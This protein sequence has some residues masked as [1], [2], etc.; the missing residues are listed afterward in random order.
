MN[1]RHLTLAQ[2]YQIQGLLRAGF[3]NRSIA[4]QVGWHPS[5]ISRE[6]RRNGAQGGYQA[7]TAQWQARDRRHAASSVPRIAPTT[8]REVERA[9]SEDWSPEEIAGRHRQQRRRRVNHE[10]I[11]QHIAADR[12]AGGTLWRHLRQRKRRYRH[13]CVP[14][15]FAQAGSIH[16]R[17][18]HVEQRQQS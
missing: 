13:R 2:R 4:V 5:T 17:P 18:P 7:T 6:R 8:W 1:Y 11:Y 15:R 12:I 10:R 9:L 3:P 14:G 16:E